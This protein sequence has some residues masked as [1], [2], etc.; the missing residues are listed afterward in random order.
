VD[1]QEHKELGGN[2]HRFHVLQII[3]LLVKHFNIETTV[4]SYMCNE[5]DIKGVQPLENEIYY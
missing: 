2:F 1:T 4:T 5:K 3:R